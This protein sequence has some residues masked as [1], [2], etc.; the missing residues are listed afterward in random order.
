MYNQAGELCHVPIRRR[1]RADRSGLH[2]RQF[3]PISLVGADWRT[4]DNNSH[5][6]Q[7]L[8]R[9]RYAITLYGIFQ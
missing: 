1:L 5:P 2:L 3:V 9:H 4:V 7:H 8:A 6:L